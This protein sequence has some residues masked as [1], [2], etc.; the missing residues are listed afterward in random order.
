MV[1]VATLLIHL[2]KNPPNFPQSKIEYRR[3]K[4]FSAGNPPLFVNPGLKST[5]DAILKKLEFKMN[6][7]LKINLKP[8]CSPA[9]SRET[10]PLRI[11][12][13]MKEKRESFLFYSS[14]IFHL[15][16][17]ENKTFIYY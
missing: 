16:G 9:Q 3:S 2:S 14:H 12:F 4:N 15:T 10:I 6:F 13:V 1:R 5:R 11:N 7:K 17:P 8:I